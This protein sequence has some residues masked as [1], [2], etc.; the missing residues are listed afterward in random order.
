[1][2]E[3]TIKTLDKR[4]EE[5]FGKKVYLIGIDVNGDYIWLEAPK[6]DCGWYWG[7]GYIETYT[8]NKHPEKSNDISSHSHFNHCIAGYK[9]K[10]GEYIHH[11]HANPDLAITTLTPR[12][13]WLLAEYMK[14]FY[15]LSESAEVFGRGGSHVCSESPAQKNIIKDDAICE[16]INKKML[17]ELFK[18]IDNLLSPAQA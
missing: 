4:T 7:F 3:T 18:L 6:W 1:M 15:T 5:A 13:S 16:K 9:H 8:N 2:E 14:T 10:D 11:P 12:E 17:P